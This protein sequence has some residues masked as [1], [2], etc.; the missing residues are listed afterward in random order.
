M[1]KRM[2]MCFMAQ[3]QLGGDTGLAN[4]IPDARNFPRG[5]GK[6]LRVHLPPMAE[7]AATFCGLELSWLQD[8]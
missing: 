8:S 4:R 6:G 5:P 1:L 3:C 7:A 2:L